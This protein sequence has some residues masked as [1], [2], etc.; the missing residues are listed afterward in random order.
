MRLVCCGE[1]FD[2]LQFDHDRVV[3]Q[4][5]QPVLANCLTTE[6]NVDREL[7]LNPMPA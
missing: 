5:I 3:N 4:K 1:R 2:R 7:T 6:D